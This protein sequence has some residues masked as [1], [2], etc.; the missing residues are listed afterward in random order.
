MLAGRP[1][2]ICR[3]ASST[4]APAIAN[5][6]CGEAK[7][8]AAPR[9]WSRRLSSSMYCATASSARSRR[10]I[11]R[12][13][14]PTISTSSVCASSGNWSSARE[15]RLGRRR[16]RAP[17]GRR[18]GCARRPR[19][20][21]RGSPRSRRRTR[22]RCSPPCCRSARRRSPSTS[23]PRGR[24]PRRSPRRSRRARTRAAAAAN[25]RRRC[26]SCR[27]S[28][29][30]A[31]RPRGTA[32]AVRG[33]TA[34]RVASGAVTTLLLPCAVPPPCSR[35]CSPPSRCPAAPRTPQNTSAGDFKGAERDVAEV[36]D[37]LKASRDPE[38]ICTQYLHAGARAGR[39]RPAAATARTRSRR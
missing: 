10:A 27:T 2:R 20:S 1:V 34:T 36:I 4:T 9:S 31:W 35:S 6:S 12:G 24:S 26:W 39:S 33:A 38:E 11:A 28:S 8:G 15:E 14:A 3:D 32:P 19:A 23:R 7:R 22:R 17:R 21:R 29:G 5:A 25:S 37:D 13:P 16:A 18:R 30:G